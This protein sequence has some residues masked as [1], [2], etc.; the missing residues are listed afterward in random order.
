M[1]RRTGT[2]DPAADQVFVAPRV[3]D[4]RAFDAFAEKLR[5]LIEEASD[6]ASRLTSTLTEADDV[7]ESIQQFS[8]RER[9]RIELAAALAEEIGE[10]A[11]TIESMLGRA[12][13]V[14][15]I[16]EGFE[17]EA[18]RVLGLKVSELEKRLNASLNGFTVQLDS[19][20]ETEL[21]SIRESLGKM[22]SGRE[23]VQKQVEHLVL[24][25]LNALQEQCDRAE[26]LIGRRFG[27]P[28]AEG[29]PRPTAG[30]LGDLIERADSL[31]ERVADAQSDLASGEARLDSLQSSAAESVARASEAASAIERRSRDAS[32]TAESLAEEMEQRTGEASRVLSQLSAQTE[33]AAQLEARSEQARAD[34]ERLESATERAEAAAGAV[35]SVLNELEPW[36]PVLLTPSTRGALPEAVAEL[37]A[38]MR[39]ALSADLRELAGAMSRVADRAAEPE[40]DIVVNRASAG[41]SVSDVD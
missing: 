32:R 11:V 14:A 38:E 30:S 10:K 9:E 4:E 40:P 23:A 15:A 34:C 27:A 21:K 26:H 28:D 31:A 20:A 33:A 17:D 29:R 12:S 24:K 2:S 25:S 5:A 13:E 39:R 8:T 41:Q 16:A 6:R 35:A 1:A 36:K 37:I 22:T 19:R 7:R 18:T 3:V